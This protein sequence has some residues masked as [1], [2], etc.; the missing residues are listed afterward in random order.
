MKL[1][2]LVALF[3]VVAGLF[4][5]GDSLATTCIGDTSL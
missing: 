2:V 5:T 3:V 4:M 1:P